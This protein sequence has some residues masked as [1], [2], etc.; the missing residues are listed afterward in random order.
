[1]TIGE[2]LRT[3]APLA[4]PVELLLPISG[5]SSPFVAFPLPVKNDNYISTNGFTNP[6][7]IKVNKYLRSIDNVND[8]S[9]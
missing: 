1:M 3:I 5:A 9:N 8:I 7:S 6:S 2:L 4:T